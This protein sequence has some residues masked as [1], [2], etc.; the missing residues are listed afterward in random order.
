M[1]RFIGKWTPPI[2]PLGIGLL[3]VAQLALLLRQPSTSQAAGYDWLQFGFDQQHSGA[4][5]LETTL[6]TANV[7]GLKILFQIQLPAN[8]I[9][10]NIDNVADDT[11]VYLAHIAV[12]GSPKDLLFLTTMPGDI[13]A[14]DAHTGTQVWRHQNGVANCIDSTPQPCF[15]AASPAIDPTRAFIY[16]YGVDGK[17]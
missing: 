8:T 13:I 14:L 16:S 2:K 15:T 6:S 4:D 1:K 12:G 3:A 7:S 9:P 5:P 10:P 17:V 11:P